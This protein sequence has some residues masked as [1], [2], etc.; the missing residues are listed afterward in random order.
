VTIACPE[1]IVPILQLGA[2]GA[3]CAPLPERDGAVS[4]AA[5][6]VLRE[7]LQGKTAVAVGPGLS[8]RAHPGLIR[9]ILESGLPAAVDADALNL[10]AE[11]REML[12]L[13]KPYHVLTPH[14]GE[15][16]RLT[17]EK[18]DDLIDGALAVRALG[19]TA[20]LKGPTSVIAG[21]EVYLSSSGTPGMARGGSGDAL[22]GILGALLA[23]RIPPEKAAWAADELHGLAGEAAA[24]KYGVVSMMSTDLVE[25]LPEVM[26][27]AI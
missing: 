7:A 13:L 10:I 6:P 1:S 5:L 25:C 18:N 17:G 16:A 21:K 14:P 12:S 8:R 20:I 27:L 24:A 23:Q 9:M 19:A 4:E 2:P 22:T 3:M 26:H 15:A 11:N